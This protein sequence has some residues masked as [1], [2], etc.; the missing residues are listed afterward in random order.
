MTPGAPQDQAAAPVERG[1]PA[2]HAFLNP[3]AGGADEE[4]DEEIEAGLAKHSSV[5]LHRARPDQLDAE[6]RAAIAAGASRVLVAGGDGTINAAAALL[7]GTPVE[8]AVIPAGTLNHFAKA[9][10][11]PT[12]LG[13]AIRV[14][15]G[16]SVRPVDVGFVNDKLFLNTSSVGVYALFVRTRERYERRFGYRIASLLAALRLL[17]YLTTFTVDLEIDGER[18]RYRTPLVFVGVGERELK[19]PTLGGRVEGGRRGLHVLVVR[20]KTGARV[21]ALALASAA[22][23]TRHVARTPH[24]DSFIVERCAVLPRAP[25]V[26]VGVDGEIVTLDSPLQFRIARDVLLVAAP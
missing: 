1:T 10:G 13:E 15:T 25:R 24:I 18:R 11:I 22:R 2:I 23:G 19:L 12:D 5:V 8:L 26:A 17:L 20:G 3:A 21:L 14:A 16:E 4:A 9:I 7:A 6:I